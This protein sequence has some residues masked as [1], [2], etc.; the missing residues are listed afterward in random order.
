[1]LSSFFEFL[2]DG[3]AFL[4]LVLFESVVQPIASVLG[5]CYLRDVEYEGTG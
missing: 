4:Q 2:T 1:M 3:F 5:H